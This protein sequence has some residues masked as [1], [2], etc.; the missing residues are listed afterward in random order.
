MAL[1]NP[2]Y[3]LQTQNSGEF[4]VGE[5]S[6]P[7]V[8]KRSARARTRSTARVGSDG[9]VLVTLPFSVAAKDALAGFC[10][11]RRWLTELAQRLHRQGSVLKTIA[12]H[13]H[14]LYLGELRE[15]V[16]SLGAS[17]ACRL[18]GSKICVTHPSSGHRELLRTWLRQSADVIL[19]QSVNYYA[20]TMGISNYKVTVKDLKTRWGSC[21]A[22]G[23][24]S[25][26]WL[27]VMAPPRVFEYVIVH[28]LAHR[29]HMNHSR[30]FWQ[31]VAQYCPAYKEASL[32]LKENAP[33][34]RVASW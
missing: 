29:L 11:K 1:D 9:V 7:F 25:L 22:S 18:E 4:I 23:S 20:L 27:L 34:L 5:F 8:L 21:S 13:Q 3:R 28:E 17:A 16:L 6:L 24:I 12:K 30:V 31:T 26:S 32:W 15:I 19:N 14:I 33:L 10:K 2:K